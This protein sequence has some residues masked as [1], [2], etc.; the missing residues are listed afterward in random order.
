MIMK[1]Q[2]MSSSLVRI[3]NRRFA[4]H[5]ATIPRPDRE[6][7]H[8]CHIN[9]TFAALRSGGLYRSQIQLARP[10]REDLPCL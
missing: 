6:S 5:R 1:N 2:K 8:M 10:T 9:L 3:H 4:L 7:G